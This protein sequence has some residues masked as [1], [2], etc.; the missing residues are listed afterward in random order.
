MLGREEDLRMNYAS[1]DRHE[2]VEE[3]LDPQTIHGQSALED[4]ANA[5][6]VLL[7]ESVVQAQRLEMIEAELVKE[8][9]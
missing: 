8:R 5:V 6:R 7:E 3:L 1:Q 4:V 2:R 9:V